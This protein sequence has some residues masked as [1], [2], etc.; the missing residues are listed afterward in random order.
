MKRAMYAFLAPIALVCSM[1][2]QARLNPSVAKC[3][4]LGGTSFNVMGK[5]GEMGVC[6]LDS[7]LICNWTLFRYLNGKEQKAVQAYKDRANTEFA[8][9]SS[10]STGM[11]LPNPAA[12]YCIKAG[13]ELEPV[14]SKGGEM[15]ICK[16]N[17]NSRIEEWT[18]FRGPNDPSNAKLNEVLGIESSD[19]N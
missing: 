14:K 11:Y 12:V 4:D 10:N 19:S 9:S 8:M 16:F 18:L 5:L 7:S 1:T 6:K 13:G 3:I 17:D 15:S 2:A